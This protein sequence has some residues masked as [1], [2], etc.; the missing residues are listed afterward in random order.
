[1]S[2]IRVV[3]LLFAVTKCQNRLQYPVAMSMQL[4]RACISPILLLLDL[5][6]WRPLPLWHLPIHT[7]GLQILLLVKMWRHLC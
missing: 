5:T 1:M 2:S 6:L 7:K 3:L 4:S